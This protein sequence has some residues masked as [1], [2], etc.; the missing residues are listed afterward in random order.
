[1]HCVHFYLA[2]GANRVRRGRGCVLSHSQHAAH[3]H[4]PG[5]SQSLG[6]Q[7]LEYWPIHRVFLLRLKSCFRF[8]LIRR[9][10]A[11]AV[12]G[13]NPAA[14]KKLPQVA[15]DCDKG[16]DFNLFPDKG[17]FL[18]RPKCRK[19]GFFEY[20]TPKWGSELTV[21]LTIEKLR[22]LVLG[23]AVLLLVAL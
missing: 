16:A 15:V 4:Q 3:G 19:C 20:V 6:N 9:K 7:S 11:K 18:G 1:M 13:L 12:I 5:P 14:G 8:T 17:A 22:T 21:R 2:V 23:A 10:T